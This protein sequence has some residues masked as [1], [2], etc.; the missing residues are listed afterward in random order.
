MAKK[1]KPR[2]ANQKSKAR[3]NDIRDLL[4][5]GV[6]LQ[7]ELLGAAVQVWSTMFE[8]MAAYSK[9]TSEEMFNFSVR[10]DANAALDNIIKAGRQK[11]DKLTK[12]PNE[13]G[14]DFPDRV[15]ARAKG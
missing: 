10:G 8:S 4:N 13:I 1:R 7:V 2:P 6:A 5:H 3:A 14:I 11:L 15:R 9:L 12:L